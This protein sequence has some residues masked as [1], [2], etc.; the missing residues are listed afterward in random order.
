MVRFASCRRNF[1]RFEVGGRLEGGGGDPGC[2]WREAG[3]N[4][5]CVTGM[6]RGEGVQ[7]KAQEVR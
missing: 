2:S 6:G 4:L 3:S 1:L 5:A 7:S